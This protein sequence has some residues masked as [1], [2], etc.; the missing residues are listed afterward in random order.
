MKPKTKSEKEIVKLSKKLPVLSAAQLKY[1]KEKVNDFIGIQRK[2]GKAYCLECGHTFQTTNE[3]FISCPNCGRKLEMT[4]T[5]KSKMHCQPFYFTVITTKNDYQVIRHFW[6]EI[7]KEVGKEASYFISEVVQNWISPNGVLKHMAKLRVPM[8]F[9]YDTWQH[10]SDLEIRQ[11]CK[12][13]AY[14]YANPYRI[15]SDV[16]YPKIKITDKI[17]QR[18]YAGS[19][20][21]ITPCEF[22]SFLLKSNIGETLLKT[23]DIETFKKSVYDQRIIKYWNSYKICKRH[24]YRILKLNDWLDHMALLEYFGKDIHNPHYICP[25]DFNKEHQKYIIKKNAVEERKR[26]EEQILKDKETLQKRVKEAEEYIKEKGKYF[27]II[28]T[29]NEISISVL[30]SIEEVMEEGHAMHHCVFSNEYYS[31]KDCLLLSAKDNNGNRLETIEL[32]L[33]DYKIEQSKGK[34]NQFTPYHE[35]IIELLTNNMNVIRKLNR[36]VA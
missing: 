14:Y 2:S 36:K 29:D 1:I 22:F 27:N 4:V 16:V 35:R 11:E 7:K 18:G 3:K 33:R 26:Q 28:I 25:E 9:Y 24:N 10:Y 21:N 30:K 23:G 19:M 20:Y 17:I 13:Y 8:S 31:R 5:K 15:N 6:V 12:G 34:Y 32:S